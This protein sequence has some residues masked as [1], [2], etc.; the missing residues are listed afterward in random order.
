MD[1]DESYSFEES[2]EAS[3]S[4][5]PPPED[6][7]EGEEEEEAATATPEPRP[8]LLPGPYAA[9]FGSA[10]APMP[11]AAAVEEESI[12]LF[13]AIMSDR[14]RAQAASHPS[15]AAVPQFFFRKK[16]GM[17]NSLLSRVQREANRLHLFRLSQQALTDEHLKSIIEALQSHLSAPRDGTDRMNYD[18]FCVV[19]DVIAKLTPLAAPYFTASCF[20]KFP[21]DDHDRISTKLFF[22]YVCGSV[23]LRQTRIRLSSYDEV[24]DSYLRE[25]DLESYI[26]DLIPTLAN[27]RSLQD[28]L[29]Q[30]YVFTAV[31]KFMY[32][33]DA[34]RTGKISIRDIVSSTMMAELLALQSEGAGTD[35]A[36]TPKAGD[37]SA[38]VPPRPA[39]PPLSTNWFSAANALRV[40][41]QYLELDADMNGML[42]KDEMLAY[43]G[44]TFTRIFFDRLFSECLT[45]VGELDFKMYLD[46][47]LTMENRNTPEAMQFMFRLLDL[48]GCGY[49]DAPT[50]SLLFRQVAAKMTAAGHDPVNAADVQDEIFDMAHPVDPLRITLPD[51]LACKQGHTILFMLVDCNAFWQ[52]D[53]RE[54]LMQQKEEEET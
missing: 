33:L 22:N 49:L 42:S 29:K 44:G 10:T 4:G 36:S 20:L 23:G 6:V 32:F 7:Q 48:R 8:R 35:K 54:S 13:K 43:A 38:S 28:N 46:F 50:I 27:L 15:Y 12:D 47:V 9:L 25:F 53:N 17:D 11:S 1:P 40:Y 24:G 14:Q 30:F 39:A 31:R 2:H 26:G 16:A 52:Y 51:L 34:K 18:D 45:Y 41:Q 21:R 37:P 3:S 19:R 5:H